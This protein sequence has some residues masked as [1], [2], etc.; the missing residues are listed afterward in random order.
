MRNKARFGE[1]RHGRTYNEDVD[2]DM[3]DVMDALTTLRT[4]ADSYRVMP[5][6]NQDVAPGGCDNGRGA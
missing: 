1:W 3:Q 5:E 2:A 4:N 6:A